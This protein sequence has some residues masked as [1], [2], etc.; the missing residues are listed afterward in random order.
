[1]KTQI[2]NLI[3]G[4]RGTR[5]DLSNK[6]YE[7]AKKTTLGYKGTN[8][9]LRCEIIQKVVSEN[10]DGMDVLILGKEFHL[11][12]YSSLTGKTVW[13][14]TNITLEDFMLLSGYKENPFKE[15]KESK[16]GLEINSDMNVVLHKWARANEKA[17]MKHRG[18]DYIDEAFVT[19]L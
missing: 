13:F 8:F 4:A 3:N 12:R 7:S 9:K 19:I 17:K 2:S 10:P 16:F 5:R 14:K 15:S 18:F 6:K 1:M 11:S